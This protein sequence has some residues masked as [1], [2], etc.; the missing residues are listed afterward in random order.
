MAFAKV[1]GEVDAIVE[2]LHRYIS[3]KPPDRSWLN[4]ATFLNQ[5]RWE[6]QPAP[7]PRAQNGQ[8]WKANSV[9]ATIDR[10]D[11]AGPEF[12][13]GPR[14]S[15]FRQEVRPRPDGLLTAAMMRPTLRP[16]RRR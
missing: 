13:I 2:G 5:R 10:L 14:P 4:P 1:A 8:P 6:D 16:T 7:N 12:I 15:L 3:A 9:S 11:A